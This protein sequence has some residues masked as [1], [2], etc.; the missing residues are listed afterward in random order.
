MQSQTLKKASSDLV[1]KKTP[2]TNLLPANMSLQLD[3]VSLIQQQ[4]YVLLLF[5]TG[6]H[7]TLLL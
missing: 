5:V 7:S 6:M 2:M 1:E 4:S 3:Q